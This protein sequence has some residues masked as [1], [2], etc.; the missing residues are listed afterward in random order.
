MGKGG[1]YS[2]EGNGGIV[3]KD[4]ADPSP[5]LDRINDRIRKPRLS[6]PLSPEDTERERAS[7]R[8][9]YNLAPVNYRKKIA[10]AE[11]RN[12]NEIA[13]LEREEALHNK[14]N[15]LPRYSYGWFLALLELECMASSEKN[16]DSKT[17]FISFG[18]VE[19]D[20]QSSRTIVLK[21]PNRFIPP[22]IEE[23]SGVPVNLDFGNGRTEKLHIESFTAREFSL[24]GKLVSADELSGI[25][26]G[27]VLGARI[28]IQNPSFL[29]QELLERFRELRFDEK[30]DMK[31]SLPRDIEFVFGPPGTGKTTHLAEKILI[32]MVH[33]YLHSLKQERC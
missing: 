33:R 26:L 2:S 27:E 18:K 24:F 6:S 15:G 25:D 28:E 30:F 22:S 3:D 14:A 32:P 8:D 29:L 16:A 13:K 11:E 20:S 9:D 21:E 17:I 1:S 31:A 23:F 7:D 4:D 19:L 5:V 10:R 12:A